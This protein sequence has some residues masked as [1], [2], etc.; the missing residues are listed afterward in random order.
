[1]ILKGEEAAGDGGKYLRTALLRV[2][3]EVVK[4]RVG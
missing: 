3:K 1:M 4:G 2:K